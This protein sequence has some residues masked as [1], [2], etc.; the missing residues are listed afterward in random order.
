MISQTYIIYRKSE[1]GH[2]RYK[3]YRSKFAL[4]AIWFLARNLD[5]WI[6]VYSAVFIQEDKK[7]V[8]ENFFMGSFFMLIPEMESKIRLDSLKWF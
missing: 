2:L 7:F 6:T 4:C 1:R 5:V 3:K 8:F